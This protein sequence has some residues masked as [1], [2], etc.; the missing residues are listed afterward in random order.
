MMGRLPT[1]ILTPMEIGK[2]YNRDGSIEYHWVKPPATLSLFVGEKKDTELIEWCEHTFG[3]QM[4]A[5]GKDGRW[6]HTAHKFYFVDEKD[7]AMFV[8]RVS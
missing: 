5:I 1:T 7:M 8:L 6:F 4:T 2:T 3:H